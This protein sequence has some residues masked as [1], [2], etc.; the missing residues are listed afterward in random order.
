MRCSKT[1]KAAVPISG[2]K[3]APIVVKADG[4]AAGKGV[5]ICKTVDEAIQAVDQIMVEKVFG[6]AGK[7]VVIEE[8]L[9]GEE[10]SYIAFTDG[11]SI[12]PMASSQDHKAVFDG[13]EGPN[14]GGHGGLFAC[15][16][17]DGG[18]PR[19]DSGKDS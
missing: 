14:T 11:K 2:R 19:E 8:C 1:G 10:A 4:L 12:L 5:F 9:L 6:E 18:S 15:A 13:D 7:R 3:G 16:C 17:G